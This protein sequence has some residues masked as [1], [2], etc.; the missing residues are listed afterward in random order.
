[1]NNN[2]EETL[3]EEESKV[4]TP[5]NAYT[6]VSRTS[7]IVQSEKIDVNKIND[8]I[9]TIDDEP[10]SLEKDTNIINKE[11]SF[12]RNTFVNESINRVKIFEHRPHYE[13]KF[14]AKALLILIFS[15]AIYLIV[16]P[17]FLGKLYDKYIFE[18]FMRTFIKSVTEGTPDLIIPLF[19]LFVPILTLLFFLV[20][21]IGFA[22]YNFIYG[23]E[24]KEFMKPFIAKSILYSALLAI[25]LVTVYRYTKIDVV[26]PIIKILT[27]N[28]YTFSTF[29]GI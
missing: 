16:V 23:G 18:F 22:V 6:D 1:M 13:F 21:F 26:T 12:Q 15:I 8:N 9:E 14:N 27:I 2:E 11:N 25:V 17:N 29:T 20:S 28:G 3:F 7:D 10:E 19:G 5:I 4:S 24:K